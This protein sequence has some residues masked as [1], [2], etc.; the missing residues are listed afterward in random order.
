MQ[1]RY[2]KYNI[3]I[4]PTIFDW[5]AWTHLVNP[6][7]AACN[8]VQRHMKIMESFI[9]EPDLHREALLDPM[10]IGGPFMDLPDEHLS[11]VQRIL[12]KYQADCKS[13]ISIYDG[14]ERTWELLERMK[15]GYS[16]EDAYPQV[17]DVFRGVIE[18]VYNENNSPSIRVIEEL[19]YHKYATDPMQG[20]QISE[21]TNDKRPFVL[22]TPVIPDANTVALQIP[23]SDQN[24]N[25]LCAA[26]EKETDVADL[27]NTLQ[28][29]E[30]QH[31]LF[32][33]F[34][35][36][37]GPYRVPDKKALPWGSKARIRYFG[38][39][40]VLLETAEK[41][42][43]I[44]PMI[45]YTYQCDDERFTLKDLPAVIDY[46][47]ITHN[48]QDHV[49]LET[50]LQIRH[51]VRKIIVPKSNKGCYFDPSLK[52]TLKWIGFQNV[53]EIDEFETIDAF[54]DTLQITSIPFLGEHGDL[55]IQ[56]KGAFCIKIYNQNILF[57]ADSN[58]LEPCLYE[59]IRERIGSVETIFLGME[60]EGAPMSWIYGP[61]L[62]KSLAR[63]ADQSRRLNG[64]N[65][66]K[67]A[68]IIRRFEAQKVFVYAMGIEP[69][70]GHIMG[71]NYSSDAPQ[72][73]ESDKLLEYCLDHSIPAKRLFLKEELI[74]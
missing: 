40:C 5:Y 39:A 31:S 49:Q 19:L 65:F 26:R 68:D 23:F 3:Q 24:L 8:L 27:I 50:L 54:Q 74:L 51:K 62:P 7:T 15:A 1:G 30:V 67:A 37:E 21:V 25:L 11:T 43:L 41:S 36:S 72:I 58:N 2:L 52:Q 4:I 59:L 28:V 6:I 61:Y 73:V 70:L 53:L 12:D 16:L 10:M 64:S 20:V 47:L 46:V 60:C 17:P 45:S 57:L 9:A 34:F 48:H 55:N 14:L 56:T 38:H 63:G 66:Q 35:T 71:L 33:S 18:L 44:D 42:I 29:P 13:Y 69:W 22:S 32:R